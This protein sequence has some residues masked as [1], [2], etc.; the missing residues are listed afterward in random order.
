MFGYKVKR[1]KS[2][3][4]WCCPHGTLNDQESS[5]VGLHTVDFPWL[6]NTV[7]SC[8]PTVTHE[9]FVC[10]SVS[11]DLGCMCRLFRIHCWKCQRG[12]E[13]V[14]AY[15]V[16]QKGREEV[17]TNATHLCRPIV[18]SEWQPQ[19]GLLPGHYPNMFRSAPELNHNGGR[20]EMRW[21]VARWESRL[22]LSL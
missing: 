20:S 11:V 17:I 19:P 14:L 21:G 4:Y 8:P 9:I 10:R 22:T 5:H 6:G 18:V 1:E 13:L 16:A 7:A 3:S 15:V 12:M 2:R